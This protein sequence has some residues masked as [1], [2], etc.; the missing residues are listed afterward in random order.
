M[1]DWR[2]KAVEIQK[3]IKEPFLSMKKYKYRIIVWDHS[4]GVPKSIKNFLVKNCDSQKNIKRLAELEK[5]GY[6]VHCFRVNN[7]G[8]PII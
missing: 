8:T 5:Q 3:C 1:D 7:D 4:S 2:I 6:E